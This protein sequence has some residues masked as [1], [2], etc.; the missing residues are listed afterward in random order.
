MINE[1]K[2]SEDEIIEVEGEE[3]D[4]NE[5]SLDEEEGYSK[6]KIKKLQDKLKRIEAEKREALE[7]S[8]RIKADFLNSKRRIEEQAKDRTEREV[9]MFIESLLP[10]CDS[11]YMA[12]SNKENWEAVDKNWR[13]GVEGINQQL[14]NVLKDY[15]V[16]SFDPT[17]ELFDPNKHEAL[18]NQESEKEADTVLG[19]IQLGYE[20][21]GNIIRPAKVIISS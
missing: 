18:R 13:I 16:T 1:D 7:E 14:Q 17:G 2:N 9:L 6:E 21:N 19:V 20:R 12:M 5:I 4:N 11:F 10:L 3:I 8:Q 15:Q